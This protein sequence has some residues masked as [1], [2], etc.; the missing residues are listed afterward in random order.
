MNTPEPYLEWLY[1]EYQTRN[2]AKGWADFK[3]L[4]LDGITL[5]IL[6][7]MKLPTELL[8]LLLYCNDLLGDNNFDHES[9]GDM[10]N[11]YR[12]RTHEVIPE[13]IYKC[14]ANQYKI[15]RKAKDPSKVSMSIPQD[16]VM[17]KL[18]KLTTFNNHDVTNPLNELKQRGVVT[19]KGST[20][21]NDKNAFNSV[22]RA[23]G[24]KYP[25][26]IAMSS[27]D[28]FQVGIT[29]Q[30]TANPNIISTRGYVK[31]FKD[32]KEQENA[33][34]SEL[35]AIEEAVFPWAMEKDDPKRL[36][37]MTGQAVHTI[38]SS[39]SEPGI[40]L[41]SVDKVIASITS[42]DFAAKAQKDGKVIDIDEKYKKIYL[43]YT[44][45]TKD[46]VSYG[47]KFV[48]NSSYFFDLNYT[49]NVK[50]GETFK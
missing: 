34:T 42:D 36:S 37:Y 20:G 7:D 27:P 25:G 43:E 21:I 46:F 14:L 44:D 45:G 26:I 8:E 5:E 28:N 41:T 30:L 24:S 3:E 1:D 2:I 31:T 19:F 4:C 13:T 9:D 40:V 49:P 10:Q 39:G 23:Y 29:K 38:K 32:I 22:K 15:L 35:I 12:I 18:F 17:A 47:D 6:R 33:T 48:S 16:A 11:L 50:K